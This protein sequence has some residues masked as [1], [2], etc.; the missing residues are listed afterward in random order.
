VQDIKIGAW[1]TNIQVE[2][3]ANGIG[4]KLDIHTYVHK[5]TNTHTHTNSA[6]AMST[7]A[8]APV[9]DSQCLRV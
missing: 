2:F 1:R 5:D 8:P 4:F 3:V 7:Q 9:R 6:A